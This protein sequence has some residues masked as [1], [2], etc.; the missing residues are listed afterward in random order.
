MPHSL[1]IQA[2]SVSFCL[3]CHFLDLVTSF[4]F[5]RLYLL[6]SSRKTSR[7]DKRN[8]SFN[9]EKQRNKI[10][11]NKFAFPFRRPSCW[12]HFSLSSILPQILPLCRAYDSILWNDFS[13]PFLFFFSIPFHHLPF[14]IFAPLVSEEK[15]LND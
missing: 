14:L 3:V 9:S 8:L 5:H 1:R 12:S 7:M 2:F 10:G 11:W 15:H 6:A 4:T 13:S